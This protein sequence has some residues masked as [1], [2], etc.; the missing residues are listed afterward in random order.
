MHASHA[1]HAYHTM[2]A[3]AHHCSAEQTLQS[4]EA[5]HAHERVRA[6]LFLCAGCFGAQGRRHRLNPDKCAHVCACKLSVATLL[7]IS[8]FIS[9]LNE[10]TT[11]LQ[12]AA[13]T[14]FGHSLARPSAC[15]CASMHLKDSFHSGLSSLGLTLVFCLI[16]SGFF[17]TCF[18]RACT[19]CVPACMPA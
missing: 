10:R 8:S 1:A 17:P 6:D 19:A 13:F 9:S 11:N 18:R 16:C 12:L 5:H 7:K 4:A 14:P 2:Y 15:T 3:C